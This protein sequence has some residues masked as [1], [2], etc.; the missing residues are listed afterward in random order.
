MANYIPNGR[1]QFCDANGT[2]LALG[3]VGMYVVGT[4]TPANT[5]QDAAQ[6]TLNTNPIALDAGGF[7]T[8]YG[9]QQYRQIVKDLNANVIWDRVVSVAGSPALPNIKDLGAKMDGSDDAAAVAAAA[10]SGIFAVPPGTLSTSSAPSVFSLVGY[11][12]SFSG[13]APLDSRYPAFE[14]GALSVIQKGNGY[15]C[16]IGIADNN[17]PANS[18]VEPCG[19]TGYGRVDNA[20]NVVFG[21]FGRADLHGTTGVATN[22]VNSFNYGAAPSV[23]N[24]PPNRAIGTTQA[25]PIALT[26]SAG[27]SF[28]SSIGIQICREGSAPQSFLTGIYLN[29]DSIVNYGIVVDALAAST[30]VPALLKHGVGAIALQLQGVGTPVA[31]NAV[32]QYVDGAAVTQFAIKQDGK[33]FIG[34]NQVLGSRDTGW[35]AMTGTADK[36]TAFATSTVTLAQLAG[37]VMALQT[38]L[39]AHGIVGA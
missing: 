1:Q 6:A 18:N 22:E 13:S 28:S 10:A 33:H 26:V 20:G 29:P 31:A 27:G 30:Q 36:A 37:R 9:G 2:P 8:I 21:L 12:A 39:T 7:A 5:W 25:Q 34:G 15:N 11:G 16:F 32:I 38:A 23:A 19:I 35:T 14:P 4:L 3:T 17:L 24:L